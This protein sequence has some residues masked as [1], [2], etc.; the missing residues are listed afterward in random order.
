MYAEKTCFY[1]RPLE[2]SHNT[3]S[4]RADRNELGHEVPVAL[5]VQPESLP[6][7]TSM[8]LVRIF[9]TDPEYVIVSGN[10]EQ[11]GRLG[12]LRVDQMK[13]GN[14]VSGVSLTRLAPE[15]ALA[16]AKYGIPGRI[17]IQ[18]YLRSGRFTLPPIA[19]PDVIDLLIQF[20]GYGRMIRRDE[21]HYGGAVLSRFLRPSITEEEQISNSVCESRF[22]QQEA[23]EL[24]TVQ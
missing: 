9:R 6:P 17:E 18:Q 23:A 11:D 15:H 5:N 1:D 21:L 10:Y 14:W 2:S 7:L 20:Y 13:G 12:S 16:T 19:F 22:R 8:S 24:S 4:V 3:V